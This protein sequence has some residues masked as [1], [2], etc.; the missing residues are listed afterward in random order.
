M[1]TRICF[2]LSMF[3]FAVLFLPMRAT[4][5]GQMVNA[6]TVADHMDKGKYSSSEIKSYL[7]GLKGATIT[8]DGK[9]RE[10]LTGK[11]GTRVVLSVAA[12]RSGDFVVDVYVKEAGSLHSGDKVSCKGEYSRYNNWT[13]NGIALKNGSCSKK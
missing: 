7:K 1:N 11:T 13:L 9:I 2:M 4:A 10:I 6:K 5:A 12:G 3:V 8:T